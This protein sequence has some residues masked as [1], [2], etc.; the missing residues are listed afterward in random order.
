MCTVAPLSASRAMVPPAR[1][2]KIS[3]VGAEDED[4]LV[5]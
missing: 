1:E 5:I 4:A 2:K 3:G